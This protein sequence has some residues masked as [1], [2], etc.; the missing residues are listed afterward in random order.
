MPNFACFLAF[1]F[2]WYGGV[3]WKF[4]IGIIKLGLG[5]IT[6]Q[7]F[8]PISRH[9]SEMPWQKRRRKHLH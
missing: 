5:Q 8:A 4:W 3:S 6:M 2:F 9:I 7:N 1:N